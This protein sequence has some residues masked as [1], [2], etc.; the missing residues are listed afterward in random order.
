MTRCRAKTGAGKPCRAA[1][2]KGA[3]LC[4]MHSGRAAELGRIGG[5]RRAVRPVEDLRALA[6]PRTT[7]ELQ[8][9]IAQAMCDV[10]AG[11]L[12][13]KV[14]NA[15]S[16]LGNTLLQAM[17]IVSTSRLSGPEAIRPEGEFAF[18]VYEAK[19]LREKKARWAAE[20]EKKHARSFSLALKPESVGEA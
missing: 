20:L 14:G 10:R 1:A 11:R 4:I 9:F 3:H 6:A 17:G 15:I 16:I 5:R 8:E 12:D 13:A 2:V 7:L 19:W 18:Q